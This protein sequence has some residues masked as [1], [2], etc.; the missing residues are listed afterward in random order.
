MIPRVPVLV[1]LSTL[2]VSLPLPAE[3]RPV[4]GSVLV[5]V[6]SATGEENQE[7]RSLIRNVIR[8]EVEDRELEV[9]EPE[10]PPPQGEQPL[11]SAKKAGVEFALVASY[12]LGEEEAAFA[13]TWCETATKTVSATV[14]RTSALDFTLDVA[15][16]A[17][18]VEVLDAQKDRIA[19]LPLK[20]DPNAATAPA[21]PSDETSAPRIGQVEL[22]RDVVRLKPL[23]PLLFSIGAAP[24]ISTFAATSFIE[25]VY[26]AVKTAAAWRF[27]LLG[28][29]G[30]IGIGTGWQRYYV[31]NT[32][33]DGWFQAIPAGGQLQYSSRGP[34]LID[35]F[36]HADGGVVFWFLE[37]DVG[38][39]MNG[40]VPF[41]QGGVGF[42]VN[43][44]ENLGVA[45]DVNYALYFFNPYFSFLEPSLALVL[46]F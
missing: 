31:S 36:V 46:K 32:A 44:L 35:F 24:L 19:A 14:S 12:T 3:Y 4:R 34:G 26:L 42:I 18:V 40:V 25:N 2:L 15:L 37:P 43:M 6:R 30:G 7:F 33:S 13:L 23:K 8:V 17:A 20:P 16:A 27:P 22:G 38:N 29:A 10:A 21:T 45:I 1:L 5:L 39:L 28:G 41:V 9:V 11:E